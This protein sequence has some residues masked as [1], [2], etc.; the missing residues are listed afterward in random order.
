M[1]MKCT[2]NQGRNL[3]A[4]QREREDWLDGVGEYV[5]VS[6]HYNPVKPA[7]NGLLFV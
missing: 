1:V 2:L 4:G 7:L 6:V 5:W 3:A